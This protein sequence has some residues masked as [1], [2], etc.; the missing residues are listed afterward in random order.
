MCPCSTRCGNVCT[1][2]QILKGTMNNE[3]APILPNVYSPCEGSCR[4]SFDGSCLK[5]GTI[6]GVVFE[7]PS[8]EIHSHSFK[9]KL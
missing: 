7:I 9:F 6:E 5:C 2:E 8:R 3:D 1:V 4:M